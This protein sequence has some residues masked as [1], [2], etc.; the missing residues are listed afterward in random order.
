MISDM[1]YLV[2]D[3]KVSNLSVLRDFDLF[4]IDEDFVAAL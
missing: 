4:L 2:L 1:N 3:R